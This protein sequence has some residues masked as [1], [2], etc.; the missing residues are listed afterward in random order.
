MI[1]ERDK[2]ENEEDK[3]FYLNEEIPRKRRKNL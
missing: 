3:S 1:K 2:S